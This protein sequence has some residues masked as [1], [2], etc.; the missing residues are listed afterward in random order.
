M[1]AFTR[2]ESGFLTDAEWKVVEV[3]RS[4]GPRSF[5]PEGLIA[6]L[7]RFFGVQVPLG[8]ENERLEKLR[9]FSVRAWYWDLIRTKDVRALI[10]AGYSKT[11]VDEIL[12]HVADFR[13]FT[14]TIQEI[15][16]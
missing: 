8:L 5:N 2:I 10:A 9:R 4:D 12:A 15:F 7:A 16:A 3:A 1:N 14:P 6:N 13:G 11:H